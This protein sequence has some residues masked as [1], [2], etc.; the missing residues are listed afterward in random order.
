[1]NIF[2]LYFHR[3]RLLLEMLTKTKVLFLVL[4]VTQLIW[5]LFF[6]YV[7]F[8]R[9][10]KEPEIKLEYPKSLD[11]S[12][13]LGLEILSFS[14]FDINK[15]EFSIDAHLYID[16]DSRLYSIDDF[17]KF[18]FLR[19]QISAKS[20]PL[21]EQTGDL[22][23]ATYEITA[24]FKAQM[25]Y[26]DFPFDKHRVDLILIDILPKNK[27]TFFSQENL[28][29]TLDSPTLG[30]GWNVSKST[31]KSG[32]P[33][34]SQ[35]VAKDT[36]DEYQIVFSFYANRSSPK[37]P[38]LV[39]MPLLLLFFLQLISLTFEVTKDFSVI[40]SLSVGSL[41]GFLFYRNVMER[42]MPMTDDF[43]IADKVYLQLMAYNIFI[44]G[45]QIYI[46]HYFRKLQGQTHLTQLLERAVSNLDI[47][48]GC[49]FIFC[50]LALLVSTLFILW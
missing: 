3:Q 10:T 42:L 20:K 46:L 36:S 27:S 31:I 28:S 33:D 34:D 8:S 25:K 16:F 4:I 15:D 13:K 49:L 26:A 23:H 1:M 44:L 50:L 5:I 32:F 35:I 24:N 22:I 40:L 18:H 19:G 2:Q 17:S 7:Y 6:T 41:S 48:R 14:K 45:I 30:P 29:L 11:S 38:I 37:T 9:T 43:I 21:I 12:L 39:L 47:I